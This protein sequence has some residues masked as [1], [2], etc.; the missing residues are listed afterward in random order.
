MVIEQYLAKKFNLLGNNE[1]ETLTINALYSNIH[2]FLERA[3]TKMTWVVPERRKR[4]L[5]IFLQ[6]FLPEFIAD[7]EMHLR[8]NS[9][10]GFYVG[11]RVS[12]FGSQLREYMVSFYRPSQTFDEQSFFLP[13]F[14]LS[15][16]PCYNSCRWQISIWQM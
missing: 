3:L 16:L 11:D 10:N 12:L 2:F 6:H 15:F 4:G 13:F 1:W 7:H 9:C 14:T 8:A 5:E